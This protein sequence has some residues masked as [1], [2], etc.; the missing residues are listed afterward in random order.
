MTFV[1]PDAIEPVV[2]WRSFYVED[3]LLFS[4]Q[5]RMPWPPGAHARASCSKAQWF[6]L[7]TQ[8]TTEERLALEEEAIEEGFTAELGQYVNYLMPD[9]QILQ[10]A[11]YMPWG[12]RD[13]APPIHSFPDEGKDWV[14]VLHKMGHEAPADTCNC[15]IHLARDL[16]L[17]LQYS[18]RGKNSVFGLV[19]GWGKVIPGSA[20][21]R[22]EFAYPEKLFLSSPPEGS[23]DLSAYGVPLLPVTKCDKF[24]ES[25]GVTWK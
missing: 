21:F 13:A 18:N 9:G 22:V 8:A 1:V 6:Y 15:G 11:V 17:A 7:W 24:L 12:M 5:Q 10:K 4:P 19:K 20:G 2:G 14:L 23:L 25:I 3:G 16:A